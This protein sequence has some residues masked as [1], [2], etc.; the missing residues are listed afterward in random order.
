MKVRFFIAALSVSALL[1]PVP[2][3]G[4]EKESHTEYAQMDIKDCTSCHEGQGIAPTHRADWLREH[5]IYASKGG[6]NCADCH[7]QQFCLDCHTGGGIDADL[8]VSNLGGDYVPRSHRTDWREIHPIKSRDNPQTCFRCHDNRFCS[9]CH[10]KFR[11]EDLMVR[12]HRRAWRDGDFPNGIAHAGFT[13]ESCPSCHPSGLLNQR[14]WSADHAREARRN[15]Q[16]CQT[17]HSDGEICMTCHSA[18]RG[19]LVN[20]HPRNWGSVK[21]NYRSKSGGKSCVRCHDNY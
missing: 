16:A 9:A 20:P 13:P 5:R 19:L 7:N 17:C 11:G 8:K 2:Q 4:A 6:K 1:S 3:A 21:D 18:R 12:S 10:A 14:T 15:L